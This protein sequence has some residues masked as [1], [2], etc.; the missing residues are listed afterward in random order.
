[1]AAPHKVLV[2]LS[3]VREGR[4][5]AKVGQAVMKHLASHQ[6]IQAEILGEHNT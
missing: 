5:G 4:H 1:M 2:V 6:S 3:S